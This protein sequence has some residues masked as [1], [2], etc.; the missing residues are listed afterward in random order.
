MV[1]GDPGRLRQILV[2]LIGNAIKFTEHG[3]VAVEVEPVS[4]TGDEVELHFTVRDTGIGIPTSKQQHVF[5]A[6]AQADSSS[7]RKYGGTGL[8]L[9][10][11]SQL[12]TL[13]NGW[14]WVESEE[15]KGSTFHFTVKLGAGTAPSAELTEPEGRRVPAFEGRKLRLLVVEDSPVN[16]L[17]AIRLIEKHQHTCAV[18]VNGREAL[19][20]IANE[21]FDCVLMDVQMPEMDGLEATT[22][23]RERER[24]TGGHLPI[25]AMTAHAMAG[26]SERCLASGMDGYITKPINSRDLFGAIERVLASVAEGA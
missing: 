22:A 6:F 24:Q 21:K 8:G 18:A 3:E 14:I 17:L 10:I 5:G 26:D 13:M 7:T 20:R 11:S 16:R 9:T 25:I 19:E 1:A 4:V 12:V 23:V 15:G 2:N